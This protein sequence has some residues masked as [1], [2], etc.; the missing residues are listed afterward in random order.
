MPCSECERLKTALINATLKYADADIAYRRAV[1]DA[2]RQRQDGEKLSRLEKVAQQ[3]K[4]MAEDAHLKLVDHGGIHENPAAGE[5]LASGE[6]MGQ[7]EE[8][9]PPWA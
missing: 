9:N 1:L 8:T 4:V 3:A 6:A 2:Y 5:D 7:G